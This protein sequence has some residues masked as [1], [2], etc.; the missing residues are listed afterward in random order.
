MSDLFWPGDHRA[1]DLMSDEALFRA[2]VEVEN[3][4]LTALVSNGVAPAEAAAD[5]RPLVGADDLTTIAV[6]AEADGNP[7]SGLVSLLRSRTG[8]TAARWL[9]R[10]LTSQDT[11]DTALMMCVRDVLRRVEDQVRT[12]VRALQALIEAHRDA[13]LLT[14]TLTQPALPGTAGRKFGVWLTAILDAADSLAA[15][16][17]IPV[18][19]GGAAG[20]LAA[21]VELAGSV[22]AARALVTATAGTVGLAASPPWHTT[23]ATT[24]RIGDALVTCCDAWGHLAG[25]LAI[26]GRP[27]IGEFTEGGGGGS[28]TM[29]HKNNP[30]LTVLLRRAA[31]VAPGLAATLHAASAASID[32]RSDGGWHAEWSTLRTLSRHTVTAAAQAAQ[33]LTGLQF[34][35]DRAAANLVSAQ[36]ILTE[37]ET[38][39]RLAGHA[40]SPDYLGAT[41]ILVDDVVTRAHRYLEGAHS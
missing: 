23:R 5:L 30:V 8:D 7:V 2:L 10:G 3:A 34:H 31:L 11:L 6:D 13:P 28:S 16:P 17:P 32:E 41:D 15:L 39:S 9:H 18:Q 36:G 38:M 4:W 25:D 19:I 26:A 14:R 40:A 35:P 24:T 12:Q 37:Q 1:G 20:T 22:Q 29:P 33:L 27:E 21:P